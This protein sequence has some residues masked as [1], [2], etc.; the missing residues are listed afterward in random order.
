MVHCEGTKID[1]HESIAAAS[2]LIVAFVVDSAAAAVA[3]VA[4]GTRGGGSGGRLTG[5]A[6]ASRT[7]DC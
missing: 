3:E 2:R 7:P 4:V 1:Y 6:M 5:D